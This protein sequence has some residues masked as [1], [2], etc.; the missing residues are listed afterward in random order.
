MTAGGCCCVELAGVPPGN[1]QMCFV[2]TLFVS[3]VT[4]CPALIVRLVA[5]ELIAPSGAAAV[6]GLTSMN[7]ATDGTPAVSSRNSM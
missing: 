5:G 2:A 1:T 4:D 7:R 3:K 6:N